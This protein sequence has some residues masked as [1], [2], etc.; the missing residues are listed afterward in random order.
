MKKINKTLKE[1]IKKMR[2]PNPNNKKGSKE[3]YI[4]LGYNSS[5]DDIINAL[6][7]NNKDVES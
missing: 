4:E 1:K 6:N 3:Y 7:L 5:I 2:I